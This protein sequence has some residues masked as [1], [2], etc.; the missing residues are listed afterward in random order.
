M[1]N[2]VVKIEPFKEE[3]ITGLNNS[4]MLQQKA[5]D[6]SFNRDRFVMNTMAALELA[7]L[8]NQAVTPKQVVNCILK[9]AFLNLDFFKKECYLIYYSGRGL[10]FQTDY[11]GEIKL[12]KKHSI[13]P[14]F[15]I[16][17][18]V[19]RAGDVYEK[20]F[21]NGVRSINHVPTRFN[22]GAI[23]GAYAVA[24]YTDGSCDMVDLSVAEIERIRKEYS[25]APNSP[26]WRYRYEEMC[27]KTVL[28]LL[29]KNI[30]LD[31]STEQYKAYQAGGDCEFDKPQIENQEAENPFIEYIPEK[32]AADEA[33]IVDTPAIEVEAAPVT[34]ETELICSMCGAKLSQK[35]YDYSMSV[36]GGAYCYK[37]Q[38]KV[39]KEA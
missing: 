32:A 39:K 2:N 37:C 7:S 15:E 11:K 38:S 23:E 16:F 17:A 22:D 21:V 10:Q 13:K 27:K 14:I 4:L 24:K 9:G 31:F 28:R 6:P 30:Q 33:E 1:A 26:A 3:V 25:K 35:V 18:D 20:R 8:C 34:G 12:V 36:Y 29:C 5:L 19:V